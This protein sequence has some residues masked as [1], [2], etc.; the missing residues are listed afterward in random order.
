M[1][2]DSSKMN[3]ETLVTEIELSFVL[4]NKA[5]TSYDNRY[6]S[7]VFRELGP[8][9]RQLAIL[10]EPLRIVLG[11]LYANTELKEYLNKFIT[12]DKHEV[13]VDSTESMEIDGE[14]ASELV[15]L[16][17]VDL[18][19]HLLIQTYLL[20]TGKLDLLRDFNVYV[21]QLL[22]QYNKR[23]LDLIQA[24]IWFYIARAAE[25]N[26][27]YFSLRPELLMSLRTAELRHDCETTASII[28][29]LL[30]FYLLSHDINQALNLVEKTQFPSSTG[31]ALSARYYYYLAKINA[32]QLDYSAAHEYVIAAIRKAP[33][34]SLA[35]GFLQTATKLMIIIELL[36]G[37]IPELKTFTKQT[38]NFEPY[39][40]VTKAVR[41]GDLKLF[42]QTLAKYEE[43][44]KKENLYTLVLRLR[45][46]VIKTGIRI[47]SLSYSRISLRDICIKLH[48][49][50]E[51]AAE[52]I[53]SKAIKDGVIEASI[54]HEKGYMKSKEL[55]DVY[56]TKLPQQEF[57]QRIK[58]CLSLY[59]DS[60]KS[61]RYP[62]DNGNENNETPDTSA[63]DEE[64]EF[65]RAMED[66]NDYLD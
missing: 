7:K 64:M 12:I 47:I 23:S 52:Y 16:P 31:N 19:A 24:K 39:L 45:Q 5:S 18:Y 30:R 20:D 14:N 65:I 60:V 29:I 26:E 27:D 43:Y 1:E 8:L 35:T 21:I 4:L 17:E 11:K 3:P 48:L 62:N 33:Q 9:R 41:L 46:N 66:L 37:D 42:G 28:T 13:T 15:L 22:K 32:I 58:F 2:I 59:N 40:Q 50:S 61:M 34:T 44:F 6:I 51:D 53:V 10:V 57:D 63:L 54:N 55:L 36:M 49:D 25:V 56:S 38:G